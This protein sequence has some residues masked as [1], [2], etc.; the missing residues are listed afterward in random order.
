MIW[1]NMLGLMMVV[2]IV[3]WF[4]LAPADKSNSD[5]NRQDMKP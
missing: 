1:I 3:Y 2:A 4:W 5:E